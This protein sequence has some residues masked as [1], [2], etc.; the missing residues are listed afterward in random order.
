MP[1]LAS[2]ACERYD[3]GNQKWEIIEINNAPTLSNF[4]WAETD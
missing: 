4:G 2:S 3:V 1:E